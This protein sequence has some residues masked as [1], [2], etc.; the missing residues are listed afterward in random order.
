MVN[1]S[2]TPEEGGKTVDD[3]GALLEA[4][5]L[6]IRRVLRPGS[7]ASVVFHNYDD[8]IWAAMLAAAERAGLRQAAVSLLDKGQRSMKGYRGR[9]GLELVPFYDLVITF[10][11]TSARAPE[12]NGVGDAALDAIR[13]HLAEADRLQEPLGSPIRSLEYLYSVAIGNVIRQGG[14]PLGLSFRSFEEIASDHFARAGNQFAPRLACAQVGFPGGIPMTAPQHDR[15]VSALVNAGWAISERTPL[16]TSP[17]PTLLH[18]RRGRRSLQLL[19]YAWKITSEGKG[20]SRTDLRVQVTRNHDGA[21]LTRPRLSHMRDRVLGGRRSIRR[22]RPVGEAARGPL[23]PPCTFRGRFS[24]RPRRRGHLVVL[25]PST[26][27]SCVSVRMPFSAFL[28]WAINL[29]QRRV[30][31]LSIPEEHFVREGDSARI[32]CERV[33]RPWADWLRAGDHIVAVRSGA[34]GD[35][36]DDSVWTI[37]GIEFVEGGAP[38]AQGRFDFDCRRHGVIRDADWVKALPA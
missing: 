20:R 2:R 36:I 30:L 25:L 8:R 26:D 7:R 13:D 9:A 37:D 33:S 11:Q 3:Y 23:L 5:F 38:R 14:V 4:S 15:L 12:L 34:A 27:R 18:I 21:L 22:V 10:A 32:W 17:N 24:G 28:D 16:F 35:L 29:R 1:R 19:V 31:K 6:E